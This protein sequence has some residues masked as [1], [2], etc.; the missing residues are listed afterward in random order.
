MC[1]RCLFG[2]INKAKHSK[3]QNDIYQQQET[4][5]DIDKNAD[6]KISIDEYIG[7]MYHSTG[8]VENE[9]DWVKSE[10]ESFANFRDENKVRFFILS[11]I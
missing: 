8:D 11:L 2:I 9:P 6:G 10:R 3:W 5:D 4:L 1:F 7:D